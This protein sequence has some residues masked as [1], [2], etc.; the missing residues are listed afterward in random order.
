MLSSVENG[1]PKSLVSAKLQGVALRTP[2]TTDTYVL[3]CF[4]CPSVIGAAASLQSTLSLSNST[5]GGSSG[6]EAQH[7]ILRVSNAC[8]VVEL[9][10]VAGLVS[11]DVVVSGAANVLASVTGGISTQMFDVRPAAGNGAPFSSLQ[12]ADLCSLM[13]L[14]DLMKLRFPFAV[15][16]TP[17]L[18]VSASSGWSVRQ[19]ENTLRTLHAE[20]VTSETCALRNDTDNG[21]AHGPR[22]LASDAM[23]VF[24]S[25]ASAP[26]STAASNRMAVF[27][28]HTL[29]DV[30]NNKSVPQPAADIVVTPAQGS[31]TFCG[32]NATSTSCTLNEVNSNPFLLS[33]TVPSAGHMPRAVTPDAHGGITPRTPNG[34]RVRRSSSVSLCDGDTPEVGAHHY[35]G[36][37]E[38]TI[39]LRRQRRAAADAERAR[40]EELQRKREELISVKEQNRSVYV[41]QMSEHVVEREQQRAAIA[42]T[43]RRMEAE[44]RARMEARDKAV[45]EE[46]RMLFEQRSAHFVAKKVELELLLKE[47]H[48]ELFLAST[49]GVNSASTSTRRSHTSDPFAQFVIGEATG[50]GK[51]NA[52]ADTLA[53]PVSP[54]SKLKHRALSVVDLPDADESELARFEK[55]QAKVSFV[56]RVAAA[57]KANE[58]RM[59]KFSTVKF[60]PFTVHAELQSLL[61]R[62]D[63]DSSDYL[64]EAERLQRD[65]QAAEHERSKADYHKKVMSENIQRRVEI[66]MERKCTELE[67]HAAKIQFERVAREDSILE[68][69]KQEQEAKQRMQVFYARKHE[70]EEE[71]KRMAQRQKDLAEY[72]ERQKVALSTLLPP[73]ATRD[74]RLLL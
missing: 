23:A 15:A 33:A 69:K 58:R 5:S 66:K 34:T 70:Q 74:S 44:R 25:S 26:G 8:T 62:L 17:L 6:D 42:E 48:Q 32:E 19:W 39:S 21:A 52:S 73:V 7:K 2:P 67:H 51:P 16:I 53:A 43:E 56:N 24:R 22:S 72:L 60:H 9:L 47:K 4:V 28:P 40:A 12:A 61:G 50:A 55:E 63:A 35:T 65:E 31:F 54:G 10:H 68:K 59:S 45:I 27:R 46:K 30:Q 57:R 13:P 3:E 1:V 64:L 29:D 49:S 18:S 14:R 36:K 37:A 11:K 71:A 41:A 20:K 38:S